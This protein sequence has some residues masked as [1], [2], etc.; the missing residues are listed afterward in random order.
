MISSHPEIELAGFIEQTCLKPTTTA[1]DIRQIC[2][3]AQ[4]YR[5]GAVCVA[6]VYARLAV[7]QLHKQ[8][9]KIF[10]VVGFPLGLSTAAAKLYEA[11]EA[12]AMGV[13][14]LEVMVNLGAVKSGQ[15]NVIYEEL[16]RIVDAVSCE[17]RAILEWN[18]LDGDERKHLAEVCL[19]VGVSMLKTSAG[20]SGLV[21]TEDVQALRRVVRNQL[22]IKVAGGVHSLSQALELLAAGANRLGTSRGVEILREQHRLEETA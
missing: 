21:K 7:E 18:L 13:D 12:A 4:R 19:D 5:F 22:G 14:G 16:G 11:E 1:D 6:P 20:W 9:P 10:T 8:K 17:V 2:W 3:E 15:Y